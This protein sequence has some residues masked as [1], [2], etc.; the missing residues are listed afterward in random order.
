MSKVKVYI[1]KIGW[2]YEIVINR[3]DK[4]GIN[5]PYCIHEKIKNKCYE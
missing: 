3:Y 4:K 2:C 5:T 1:D